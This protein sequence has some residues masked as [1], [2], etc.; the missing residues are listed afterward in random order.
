MPGTCRRPKLARFSRAWPCGSNGRTGCPLC[1]GWRGDVRFE[2]GGTVVRAALVVL[3]MTD[4][5]VVERQLARLPVTYPY[6]PGLLSFREVPVLLQAFAQVRHWP[7]LVLCAGQG[8]C[9]AAVATCICSS[10]SIS[11]MRNWAM[12][13]ST[14]SSGSGINCVSAMKPNCTMS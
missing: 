8:V 4:G 2:S 1:A 10:I 7:D 14:M 13:N 12:N 6:V 5:Q 11:R 3:D 9:A